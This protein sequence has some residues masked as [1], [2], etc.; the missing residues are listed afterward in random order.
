M[1][2]DSTADTSGHIARVQELLREVCSRLTIRAVEHDMSKRV[3]PEKSG[4]DH[5]K[6]ILKT[7]PEDSPEMAAAREAMGEVLEHHVKANPGHHPSGNP[8]GIPD[9]S[10]LGLVEM[11][12]DWRAAADEKAPY[13]LLLDFNIERFGIDA[14]LA[15]VLKN[16]V[17]EL[18]W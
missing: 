6:P 14:Q 8:N 13:V 17:R 15:A 1:A 18:G 2:Y 12:A 16:T 7:L 11:L 3:E 10:L 9:M 4:Y 5:W